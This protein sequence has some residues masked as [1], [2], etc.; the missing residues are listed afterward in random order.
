MLIAAGSV[1]LGHIDHT[2]NGRKIHLYAEV[3]R[4][5]RNLIRHGCDQSPIHL[6]EN[7]VVYIVADSE[8]AAAEYARSAEGMKRSANVHLFADDLD[9]DHWIEL[10]RQV[11]RA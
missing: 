6:V 10:E 5:V 2:Q 3:S 7:K 1:I 4:N 11:A 8:S 9:P